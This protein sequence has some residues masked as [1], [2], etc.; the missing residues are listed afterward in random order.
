MDSPAYG[1][2]SGSGYSLNFDGVDD[3]VGTGTSLLNNLSQ[4]TMYGWISP[5][6][7]GSDIGFF[8]QNDCIEFG[9]YDANTIIGWTNYG[10]L[11][12]W[13]FTDATFS[14]NTMH[15]IVLVGSGYDLKIYV[16]GD[17]KATGGSST[18]N[19]STSTYDFNIGGGGIWD[20]SGNWFN[21]SIDE[22][23]IWNI[24]CLLYTSDAAD[25]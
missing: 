24:A 10:G 6:N 21:G 13:D 4:F 22:V 25:E 2:V 17:L 3:Y 9:F 14:L 20:D 5:E 11:V 18:S 12:S 16:D 15:H 8:G 23:A 7:Y 1:T 19:Y